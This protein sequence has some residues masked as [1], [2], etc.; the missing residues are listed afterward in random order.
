MAAPGF[1][2]QTYY[3]F[4]GWYFYR[5]GTTDALKSSRVHFFVGWGIFDPNVGSYPSI[6][7]GKDSQMLMRLTLQM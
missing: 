2:T 7:A 4:V 3:P 1:P 5:S 6:S